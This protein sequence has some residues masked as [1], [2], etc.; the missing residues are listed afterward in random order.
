MTTLTYQDVAGHLL[1][2][3]LEE[4]AKG[5]PRQAS[6]K[7]WGATEQM[8][9]AVASSRGWKHDSHASL[10]WPLSSRKCSNRC[11]SAQPELPAWFSS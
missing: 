1:A 10:R 5:D 2:Q 4:L 11:S 8:I 7:G 9:K 6:E 3:G